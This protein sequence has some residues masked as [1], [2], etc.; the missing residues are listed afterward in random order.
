MI[1]NESTIYQSSNNEDDK[2]N[3]RLLFG[4]NNKKNPNCIVKSV[5]MNDMVLLLH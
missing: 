1:A 3:F 4:F 5:Y 2:S